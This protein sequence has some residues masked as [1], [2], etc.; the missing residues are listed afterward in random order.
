MQLFTIYHIGTTKVP[1][2][3]I[4]I[5]FNFTFFLDKNFCLFYYNTVFRIDGFQFVSIIIE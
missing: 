4:I 1:I 5:N 2:Y 3:K